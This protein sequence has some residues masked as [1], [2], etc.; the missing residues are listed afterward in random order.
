MV[1]DGGGEKE[2]DKPLRVI[3]GPKSGLSVSGPFAV[4]PPRR[5]IVTGNRGAGGGEMASEESFIGVWS[6]DDNGDAAPRW[7]I[8]GPHGVMQMPRGVTLDVK[9]KTVIASDKRQNAVLSFYFP[10]MF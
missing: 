3:G 4:Y 5:W 9:N 7:T 8:G 1:F 10:E 2:S 6:M